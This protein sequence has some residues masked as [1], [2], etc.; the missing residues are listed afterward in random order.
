M[1]SQLAKRLLFG[2]QLRVGHV[3]QGRKGRY[4]LR[5]TLKDPIVFKAKMLE[6]DAVKSDW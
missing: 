6:S 4:E 1:A 3:L 5:E 2:K